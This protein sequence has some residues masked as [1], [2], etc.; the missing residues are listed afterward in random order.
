MLYTIVDHRQVRFE[1]LPVENSSCDVGGGSKMD[2]RVT[3]NTPNHVFSEKGALQLY[4]AL[5]RRILRRRTRHALQPRVRLSSGF[6][7]ILINAEGQAPHVAGVQVNMSVVGCYCQAD[8]LLC[9]CHRGQ[10]ERYA[11][12]FHCSKTNKNL[13]CAITPLHSIPSRSIPCSCRW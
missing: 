1:R 8:R 10:A 2:G 6:P 11:V 5:S 13:A 12:P 4:M 7:S 9:L 3:K